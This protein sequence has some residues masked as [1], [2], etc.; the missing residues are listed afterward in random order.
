MAALAH[1]VPVYFGNRDVFKFLN[2]RRFVLCAVS[3][4]TIERL[5]SFKKDNKLQIPFV[6]AKEIDMPFLDNG[7]TESNYPGTSDY[8]NKVRWGVKELKDELNH[9]IEEIKYLDQHDEAFIAKLKEPFYLD[10]RIEDSAF[11]GT[12]S[13][14]GLINVLKVLKSP[15]LANLDA[16]SKPGLHPNEL[17]RRVHHDDL[18]VE[19]ASAEIAINN[20]IN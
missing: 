18:E 19:L 15:L 5:R 10:N 2:P 11:D 6:S 12:Y 14:R 20:D 8:F 3:D 1:T 16:E 7:F 9:C 4:H 13:A 17:S